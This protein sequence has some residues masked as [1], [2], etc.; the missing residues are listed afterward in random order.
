MASREYCCARLRGKFSIVEKSKLTAGTAG[1]KFVGNVSDAKMNISEETISVEDYTS[2]AGGTHCSTTI[3][4]DVMLELVLNCSSPEN[5]ALGTLG[6]G[7]SDN[8]TAG[9][10]TATELIAWP[11]AIVVLP[12]VGVTGLVV[13]NTAGTTTYVLGTDYTLGQN[14]GSITIIPAADGGTIP[15]PTVTAGVGAANIKVTGNFSLQSIV[16]FMVASGKEYALY[17]DAV[18]T[19]NNNAPVS[20]EV[21]RAKAG[22]A[23]SIQLITKDVSDIKMKFSLLRDESKPIGTAAAP[24]S[25]YGTMQFG[26]T[27]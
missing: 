12:K 13:T 25:Q 7:A 10:F 20:F 14:G 17:F 19:M 18:N 24:L 1:F 23:D 5:L 21:F 26:L 11:G 27:A 3:I 15:A 2:A 9:A 16:Q 22:A 4:K 8:V 6:D